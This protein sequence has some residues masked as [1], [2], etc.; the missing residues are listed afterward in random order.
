MIPLR[1]NIPHRFKPIGVGIIIAINTLFFLYEMGLSRADL[2]RLFHLLGVVPARFFHPDWAQWMG[3]PAGG[4]ISF[5][6][7]MF[8]HSG[9]LH[10]LANMWILWIFADN[11]EDTMGTIRFLFFYLL[12]GLLALLVHMLFNM[13]S[14]VP[15]VGAS[16]AIAGVMGA[17]FV[18]YPHARVLTFLPI[19]FIP[20]LIEL[21]AVLFLGVWFLIQVLSG[22]FSSVASQSGAGVAWWA[23]AGGFI[24]GLLLLPLFKDDKRCYYCFEKSKLNS[25]DSD[26][27]FFF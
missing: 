13:D 22:L 18:L 2:A 14:S 7:H 16:G 10:F 5:L 19:F 24:A 26:D 12:C 6:S 17:Y 4:T 25:S 9:W 27:F 20:Y 3:Y 15:V 8:L 23:H 11:V 1:D 21:P